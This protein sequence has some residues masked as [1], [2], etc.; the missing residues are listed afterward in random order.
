MTRIR[1]IHW[2][3]EEAAT[4]GEKLR[5]AGYEVEYSELDGDGYRAL[6]NNPP[7]AFVIDLSRRPTHGMEVGTGLRGYKATRAVPLVFVE[8][9]PEVIERIQRILPD[10][11]FTN[12]SRIRSAL[13]S[14]LAHAPAN[15]VKPESN[16]AGY[17]GTPLPKKLGIKP[18]STVLLVN[19]PE[20]F[21][22]TLGELPAGAKLTT[23][24]TGKVDLIL[25]F[26][27]RRIE[28]EDRIEDMRALTGTGGIWL[29]W[30]KQA[31]GLATDLTQT[32]V[33]ET[34][35]A[36]GLVDYKVCA[37]DATWSGLKFALRKAK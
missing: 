1:L 5:A 2:N 8:G 17:S 13:K 27:R 4:R 30:P 20:D 3:A 28:L 18:N 15:P 34:G 7:A 12:W 10:A 19:A 29:A 14:A 33:R 16:L 26:L 21:T 36:C 37:I 24:G 11:T 35:L 25:W 22:Q 9:A 32:I 23:D 6:K 31:S